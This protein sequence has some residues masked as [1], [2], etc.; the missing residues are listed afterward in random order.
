MLF[1]ALVG[2]LEQRFQH[3]KRARVCLWFD[4]K[5][6][7]ARLLPAFQ[8][9][10]AARIP[11]PFVLLEY[12]AS[13][14]RGQVWLKY[15]VHRLLAAASAEERARLRFVLY[16]PL[17]EDRLDVGDGDRVRLDL[18]E[19][20]RAA[21]V[22]WRVGGKR[23]TLFTVL[24]QAGVALPENPGD[25][26][27]LY[28]GGRDSLLAK[29]VAKFVDRPALFWAT[30]L[31][32]ELAQS[33][34]IGDID[35]AIFDLATEP[36]LSWTSLQENGL[37]RE[38]RESVRERYGFDGPVGSPAMWIRE[39]VAMLALTETYL[40]YGEPGDFPFADRLPPLG[41]RM[42]HSQLLQRWLRDTTYRTA[43]DS[44]IQT[45]EAGIDLSA[46][47]KGRTGLS[48]GFPHLVRQRWREIQ[49]DFEQAA[50]KSSTTTAFFA[51]HGET[52]AREADFA[53]ASPQP[54]GAWDVLRDLRAFVE[55]CDR[56][57]QRV[58]GATTTTALVGLYVEHA[59]AV[60]GRHI[61]LRHRAEEHGLPAAARVADRAYASYANM[62]NE[63]FFRRIAGAGVLDVPGVPTVTTHLAETMWRAKGRRAVIIV[64]A[65]RYDCALA[66]KE[67]L[68]EHA[69]D[70]EPMLATLPTV[71]AIGMTALLPLAGRSV[72]FEAKGNSLHPK[73]DGKDT[74]V[75]ENRLAM[76]EAF[77]ADC[78]DIAD[79]EA[80]SAPPAGMGDLLVV[81]GHDDVDHI[82]HGKAESLI[83][84]VQA[85]I[86][87]IAR[88]VR[89]LHRWG[90][91][92]VHVVTDHGFVLLDESKL[93]NEVPCDKAWCHVLKERFA[94][95][96]AGADVP[97]VRLPFAWDEGVRVAVP[98]GL[99]FFK[100][101]KSFSHG[102]AALQ[103]LIIPHL[104]SRA[105]TARVKPVG[106]EV[107][108]PTFELQVASVKV[109]LR[110][111]SAP[112]SA[113]KQMA[114]LLEGTR[115][116]SLDVFRRGADGKPASVLAGKP[117]EIR[118]E[119][120]DNERTVTLFFHTAAAFS[121]GEQLDLDIRDVETTEQF[122]PGGIKLVVGRDM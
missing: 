17:S 22:I 109:T 54:M 103:E 38:F 63:A 40:A 70:V 42:H 31:T 24:R 49:A 93:P 114:L 65:F 19:E 10:L 105:P 47:A 52:I 41:L 102:G 73:V 72:S 69:V 96:P 53:K 3:E 33:R 45:V 21:G 9:H 112:P 14:S 60:E 95:V 20:Y 104:V 4:E 34:L 89:K 88:L 76:L 26:R 39:F 16:V 77:G 23:P 30:Q 8:A 62:L 43:W 7:F 51:R 98:P 115:T 28:E 46:W 74:S 36:D 106:V 97:L 56:A 2:Q 91:V 84:H 81:F 68:H 101:E 5:Q 66:V 11:A 15:Q 107:V 48:F 108:L 92:R 100:A 32:P 113:S 122:P 90:Y 117:K 110:P 44:W 119:P 99:A 85:E 67:L 118:V 50:P 58:A 64:D 57:E 55:V 78:R 82:G 25:Q 6:E 12:D 116:L 1:E 18:L 94:L 35:Q 86:E 83:R 111:T 120:R 37:D 87:R 61:D 121:K 75:R 13:R 80:D 79:I 71:T 59:G 29:Y 27:R